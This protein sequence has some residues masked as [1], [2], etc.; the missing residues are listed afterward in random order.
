VSPRTLQALELTGL[1]VYV[2]LLAATTLADL[3]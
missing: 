2:I 3:L 1:A